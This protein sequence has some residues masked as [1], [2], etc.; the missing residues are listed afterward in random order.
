MVSCELLR[1]LKKSRV[2][3][4]RFYWGANVIS[5]LLMRKKK[6]GDPEE[7]KVKLNGAFKSRIE[8]EER[9]INSEV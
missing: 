1:F 4:H 9:R 5:P 7:K 8:S 6:Q 3:W 2:R